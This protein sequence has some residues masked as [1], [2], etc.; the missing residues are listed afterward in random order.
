MDPARLGA[1]VYELE[2]KEP[3]WLSWQS[4]QR[5]VDYV[6]GSFNLAAHFSRGNQPY[7]QLI[8]G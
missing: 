1:L 6:C 7:A 3:M 2:R 5:F 4:Q 8:R